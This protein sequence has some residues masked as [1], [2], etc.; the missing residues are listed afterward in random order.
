MFEQRK[1]SQV[2]QVIM[3]Q[4][5]DGELYNTDG[6]GLP[7]ITGAGQFGDVY[8]EP[9]QFSKAG[10]K[11]SKVGDIIICIR[12][13]IGDLNW[14]DKEYYLG[15]GVAAIRASKNVEPKYLWH[16]LKTQKNELSRY[17]TGSTFKQIKRENIENLPIPLPPLAEQKR[18][19]EVLDKADAL[20]EKRRLAL[21]KLDTLLQSVFLEMFGDSSAFPQTNLSSVCWFITKG[22]TPNSKEIFENP[23]DNSIPF[24]KVYHIARDGSIDFD[25]KPSFVSTECHNGFLKRS[26]VYPGD[27]LMNIVGPPLG[28]IGIVPN[29]YSEWNVNQALAIFRPLENSLTSWYLLYALKSMLVLQTIL[30]QA[31][32][33]RQQNIS[34]EQCRNIKIPLPPIEL[35]KKF[36]NIASKIWNIK[37][38]QSHAD[39]QTRN[40]FQSL[41]QRAFKGE[42]FSDEPPTVEPQ[43]EKVWRLTSLS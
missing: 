43:E 30:S 36:S 16:F 34:L 8:P 27:I 6:I 39:V 24:L 35:Q 4:S 10:S 38:N 17:A 33:I 20:R 3:G 22:T 40:L 18:I 31:V 15:R 41:Q 1:L 5:P 26:K 42:L 37:E 29:K 2:S 23:S 32:G 19:V 28:K 7:L 25:Y 21:Q 12:A 11:V 9:K 14:A 13:T